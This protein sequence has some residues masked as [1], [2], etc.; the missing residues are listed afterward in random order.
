MNTLKQQLAELARSWAEGYAMTYNE[1]YPSCVG[2]GKGLDGMCAIASSHLWFLFQDAGFKPT[3]AGAHQPGLGAHVFVILD[4]EIWDI[5]ATQFAKAIP[6][7]VNMPLEVA[8]KSRWYW[9]PKL[10]FDTP[11]ELR[12]KQVELGWPDYQTVPKDKAIA[13]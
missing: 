9:N 1:Q 13:A 3:I 8:S 10:T 6:E 12:N 11:A 5:T 7:V 2:Y 4:G